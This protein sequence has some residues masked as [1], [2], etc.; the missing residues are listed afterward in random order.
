MFPLKPLQAGW[1]GNADRYMRA[2]EQGHLETRLEMSK[3][4]PA[5]RF[6]LQA[7]GSLALLHQAEVGS[8]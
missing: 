4:K 1:I 8:V 2:I 3:R 6:A 5:P 7:N